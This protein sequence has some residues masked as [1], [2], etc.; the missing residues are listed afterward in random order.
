MFSKIKRHELFFILLTMTLFIAFRFKGVFQQMPPYTFCDEDMY[1]APA[2]N[3]FKKGSIF[4]NVFLSGALNFKFPVWLARLTSLFSNFPN[5]YEDFLV[6]N[7]FVWVALL[8]SISIP[9]SFIAFK[10]G[11]YEVCLFILFSPFLMG[12]RHFFYPDHYLFTSS[13]LAVIGTIHFIKKPESN[14]GPA[15]WVVGA[16]L[17]A[18]TKWSGLGLVLP[19]SLSIFLVE[20][21]YIKKII[22]SGIVFLMAFLALNDAI[23]PKWELFLSHLKWSVEN[24]SAETFNGTDNGYLF[25]MA[26]FLIGLGVPSSLVIILG[27]IKEFKKNWKRTAILLSFP[28]LVF[29]MIGKY[30]KVLTR[31]IIIVLPWAIPFLDSGIGEIKHFIQTP[32]FRALTFALLLLLPATKTINDFR[33]DYLTDSRILAKEWT[34]KNVPAGSLVGSINGCYYPSPA[35]G[36]QYQ[37][38]HMLIPPAYPPTKCFEYFIADEWQFF[39]EKYDGII[40]YL[41]TEMTPSNMH[42]KNAGGKQYKTAKRIMGLYLSSFKHIKTITGFGPDVYFYKN[43]ISCR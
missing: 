13:L 40:S 36:K 17:S 22:I 9:L 3:M 8:G 7:R 43:Q 10:K 6:L 37:M 28:I 41:L 16:A 2:F 38:T 20:K 35:S 39:P 24:Y 5:N 23:L 30:P 25:Y 15:L 42:F 29:I 21:K 32:K 4:V 34:A 27:I 31:N 18:S 12:H 1:L 19:F 11:S 26:I 14:L 33:R